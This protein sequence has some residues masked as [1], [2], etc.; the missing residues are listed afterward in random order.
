MFQKNVQWFVDRLV[1]RFVPSIGSLMTSALQRMLILNHAEQHN[2]LEEQALR[3]EA[4][5]RQEIADQ[6]REQAKALTL[7]KP[8]PLAEQV[9]EDFD[10]A[11]PALFEGSQG[12]SPLGLSDKKRRS[13]SRKRIEATEHSQ[14]GGQS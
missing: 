11:N 7:D 3:Y 5:G 2:Q 9:L 6:I 4:A 13:K 14:E 12:A 8:L 1:E 10:A